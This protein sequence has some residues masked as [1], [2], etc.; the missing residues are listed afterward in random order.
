MCSLIIPSMKHNLECARD[1]YTALFPE[2]ETTHTT[3][4]CFAN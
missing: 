1:S 4:A 3:S 2:A